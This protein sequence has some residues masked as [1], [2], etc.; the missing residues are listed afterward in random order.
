MADLFDEE[1]RFSNIFDLMCNPMIHNKYNLLAKVTDP[2]IALEAKELGVPIDDDVADVMAAQFEQNYWHY[3]STLLRSYVRPTEL[4]NEDKWEKKFK[5]TI[6]KLIEIANKNTEVRPIVKMIVSGNTEHTL[7]SPPG[8]KHALYDC[9][10][11]LL[12]K[13]IRVEEK[14]VVIFRDITYKS[15]AGRISER[16]SFGKTVMLCALLSMKPNCESP[17]YTENDMQSEFVGQQFST[18]NKKYIQTNIIVGEG[19]TIEQWEEY[20]SKFTTLS[21]LT[22]G[23]KA[24]LEK[25]DKM[26]HS[27][28]EKIPTVLLVKNS[29][30]KTEYTPINGKVFEITFEGS[31]SSVGVLADILDDVYVSRVIFDDFDILQLPNDAT[32]PCAKFTWYVSATKK[33]NYQDTYEKRKNVR[34]VK[35][36]SEDKNLEL[37]NLKCTLDVVQSSLNTAKIDSY[38]VNTNEYEMVK[39]LYQGPTLQELLML[40]IE[41]LTNKYLSNVKKNINPYIPRNTCTKCNK[42]DYWNYVC[43]GTFYCVDCYKNVGSPAFDFY[44]KKDGKKTNVVFSNE[45]FPAYIKRTAESYMKVLS[46]TLLHI[47]NT[48]HNPLKSLPFIESNKKII[49][50][51]KNIVPGKKDLPLTANSK[52]KVIIYDRYSDKTWHPFL[53]QYLTNIGLKTAVFSDEFDV[54]EFETNDDFAFIARKT[55][56]GLNMEYVTHIISFSQYVDEDY[57]QLVGRAYRITR[58]NNL[59]LISFAKDYGKNYDDFVVTSI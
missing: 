33:T 9:Q 51:F 59:T 25:F 41:E 39:D 36:L 4:L 17:I 46:D 49:Q 16:M 27:N 43:D 42:S 57:E 10:S 23:T 2:Y 18:S 40:S 12:E 54:K 11:R 56:A 28:P 1:S 55:I 44:T 53:A 8:F 24:Q 30:L 37:F 7:L 32:L 52:I 50:E 45:V 21:Y 6:N 15:N 47:K 34:S 14:P 5:T 22:V 38:K 58:Q 3:V 26:L 20:I 29:K 35:Y 31:R 13:M 19:K 48:P